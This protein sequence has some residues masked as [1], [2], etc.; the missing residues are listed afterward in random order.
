MVHPN[1]TP[2]VHETRDRWRPSF[3]LK[4]QD[5][6]SAPRRARNPAKESTRGGWRYVLGIHISETNAL[7]IERRECQRIDVGRSKV[8]LRRHS[9]PSQAT[10]RSFKVHD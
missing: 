3:L 4:P 2:W 10:R 5:P 7:A 8:P 6:P 1:G 9:S